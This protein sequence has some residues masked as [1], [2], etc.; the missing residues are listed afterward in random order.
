MPVPPLGYSTH[1]RD[2]LPDRVPEFI[3]KGT[4]TRE[5][6]L[7]GLGAPDAQSPDGRWFAYR[8]ERHTGGVVFV[9]GGGYS[10]GVA[11]GISGYEE[12]MLIVRFDTRSIVTEATMEDRVCPRGFFGGG[13]SSGESSPCLKVPDLSSGRPPDVLA[14]R[15]FYVA[16][17][18]ADTRN[19]NRLIEAELR[20]KGLEATTGPANETPKEIDA[21]LTYE[22]I[23]DANGRID[24]LTTRIQAPGSKSPF[25][26]A[27]SRQGAPAAKAP[28]EMVAEA[29]A[30]LFAGPGRPFL[31]L[32][33]YR[34]TPDS[35]W[36]ASPLDKAPVRIDP[37]RDA[38]ATAGARSIG[39][40]TAL[41][42]WL[43]DIDVSPLPAEVIAQLLRAELATMGHRSIDAGADV[44]I[45]ARVTRFDVR[46]PS[47]LI[48]WDVDGVI[49]VDLGVTRREGARQEF[50]YEVTCTDRT[51]ISLSETLIKGVVSTCLANLGAKVREDRALGEAMDPH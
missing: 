38:R 20:R 40:R 9:V 48:Y 15:T 37:V 13:N 39:E 22:D 41:G 2:N 12:R 11:G 35:H 29:V 26:T 23:T 6:V 28:E 14:F 3:V 10:A 1:S 46:T 45:D 44:V 8:S 34:S 47:T 19:I 16:K 36:V 21:I 33:P 5:E 18:D 17:A 30:G 43:G 31:T 50:H 7:L 42:F 49:T 32:P 27:S 4:T 25:A 51:Y 24:E